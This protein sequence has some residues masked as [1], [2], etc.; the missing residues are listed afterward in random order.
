MGDTET[1]H[2]HRRNTIQRVMGSVCGWQKAGR[3]CGV[4]GSGEVACYPYTW[5]VACQVPFLCDD[6]VDCVFGFRFSEETL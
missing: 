2:R 5:R 6:G 4:V 3:S 1:I